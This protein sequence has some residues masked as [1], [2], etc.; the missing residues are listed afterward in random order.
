ML[1]RSIL[2][3]R[4]SE[5]ITSDEGMGVLIL[6]LFYEHSK[7]VCTN[8]GSSKCVVEGLCNRHD[9][10]VSFRRGEDGS[11]RSDVPVDPGL[12]N[13]STEGFCC[14]PKDHRVYRVSGSEAFPRRPAAYFNS[15]RFHPPALTAVR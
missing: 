9:E 10:S 12:W 6:V 2:S 8:E 14:G 3:S 7:N 15:Q 4:C 5:D 13:I 11:E 1:F